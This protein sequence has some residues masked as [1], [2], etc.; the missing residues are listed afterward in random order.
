MPLLEYMNCPHWHYQE[1][2][3]VNKR[4]WFVPLSM[5]ERKKE[6]TTRKETKASWLNIMYLFFSYSLIVASLP[7]SSSS[8][9]DQR[10]QWAAAMWK[11]QAW[12]VRCGN[13]CKAV[14]FM[15]FR[16]WYGA[17]KVDIELQGVGSLPQEGAVPQSSYHQ[18]WENQKRRST[19]MHAYHGRKGW[20]VH[21]KKKKRSHHGNFLDARNWAM[22]DELIISWVHYL[23]EDMSAI[24]FVPWPPHIHLS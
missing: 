2:C 21:D 22:I 8:H 4:L 1:I 14:F 23:W 11:P 17:T 15:L 16:R 7:P 5:R 3:C 19:Y 10:Q 9:K 24:L 13:I 18:T 6:N 12:D 20:S